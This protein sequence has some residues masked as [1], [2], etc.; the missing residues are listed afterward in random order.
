MTAAQAV[1]PG[2]VE[3]Q[4]CPLFEIGGTCWYFA[5]AL[6]EGG[7]SVPIG[8]L[9]TAIGGQRIEGPLSPS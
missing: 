7:L 9:D 2:C 8:I 3:K 1:P 5:E 4:N 6:A